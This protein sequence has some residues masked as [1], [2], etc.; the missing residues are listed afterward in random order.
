LNRQQLT[1]EILLG[2]DGNRTFVVPRQ[3]M[4]QVD[5]GKPEKPLL[6]HIGALLASLR[7]QC[8]LHVYSSAGYEFYRAKVK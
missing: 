2:T 3:A 6:D 7:V 1:D 8:V 5:W 4:L